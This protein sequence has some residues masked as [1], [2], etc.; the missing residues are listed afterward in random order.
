[1]RL[2]AHQAANRRTHCRSAGVIAASEVR[3]L[4][5]RLGPVDQ[6]LANTRPTR[7]PIG[8]LESL[9]LCRI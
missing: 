3:E 4:G 8:E 9:A 1:M 5:R 7:E 6:A 2:L